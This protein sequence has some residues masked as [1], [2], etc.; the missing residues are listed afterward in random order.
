MA[1]F[2]TDADCRVLD[3]IARRYRGR[4]IIG[5]CPQRTQ[6][7]DADLFVVTLEKV[8][9]RIR[10]IGNRYPYG[11]PTPPVSEPLPDDTK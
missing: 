11:V 6:G 5:D 4:N 10:E 1:E 3:E 8:A 2:I 9:L 7:K